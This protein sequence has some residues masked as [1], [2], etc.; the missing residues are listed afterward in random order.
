MSKRVLIV[1]D[2]ESVRSSLEKLL[3]FEKYTT[4]SAPDGR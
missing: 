3:A 1:D 2:E 4:F